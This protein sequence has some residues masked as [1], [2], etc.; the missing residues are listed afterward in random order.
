MW[1]H[2][3]ILLNYDRIENYLNLHIGHKIYFPMLLCEVKRVA[4]RE[5]PA[6]LTQS[7]SYVDILEII[8]SYIRATESINC[9]IC[10]HS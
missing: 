1:I 6:M 7:P 10:R 5:T 4:C 9:Y 3:A 2:T 8:Y